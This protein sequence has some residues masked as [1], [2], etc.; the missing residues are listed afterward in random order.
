MN[1]IKTKV[2][3][4]IKRYSKVENINEDE[5]IFNMGF[6]NSLFSMQLIL[7]IEKEFDISVDNDDLGTD[8][9]NTLNSIFSY[10]EDRCVS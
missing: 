9:F 6:I 3:E 4:F 2:L 1:S 8:K 10:I 7:F 5:N